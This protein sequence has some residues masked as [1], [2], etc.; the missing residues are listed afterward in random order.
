MEWEIRSAT[1][2][3]DE[4]SVFSYI[5]NGLHRL[6]VL[7]ALSFRGMGSIWACRSPSHSLYTLN[8]CLLPQKEKEAREN[9]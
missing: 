8:S 6:I 7:G 2:I 1:Y 5:L 4:Y 9:E 3:Y